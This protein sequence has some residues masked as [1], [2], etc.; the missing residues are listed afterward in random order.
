M[1]ILLPPS[2]KKTIPS[3]S[4]ALNLSVLSFAE[5]LG[6]ARAK[7]IADY[8]PEILNQSS[9]A[10]ID[11]YSGVL[12]QSLDWHSLTPSAQKRGQESLVIISALFGALRPLDL[13]AVYKTPIR[14]SDWK[15][16]VSKALGTL[17]TDLI[18]DCRSSTYSGVWTPPNEKLVEVRVFKE[19]NG[20]RSVITHM[21]KKYRG[22]LARYLLL[23]KKSA[24]D[25]KSLHALISEKFLCEFIQGDSTN[26]AKLDLIIQL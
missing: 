9:A 13:I 22:E 17:K 4:G 18:I 6:G 24:K 7:A 25:F 1:L 10:A 23:Q 3:A 26:A 2:E 14:T 15:E 8:N 20:E 21:S 12:Y 5:E 11:V 16:S 19:H